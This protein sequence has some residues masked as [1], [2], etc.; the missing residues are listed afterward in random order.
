MSK[1]LIKNK[2]SIEQ[3]K[4]VIDKILEHSKS[5]GT[6]RYLIYDRMGYGEEAYT[7]LMGLMRIIQ[8]L[9]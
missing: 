2:P 6:Y 3:T 8:A 9:R 4:W 7:E 1:G 5:S